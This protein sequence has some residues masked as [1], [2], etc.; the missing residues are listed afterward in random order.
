MKSRASWVIV[1]L[2]ALALP[3][4]LAS[5]GSQ[6]VASTQPS[7]PSEASGTV[8]LKS[9]EDPGEGRAAGPFEPLPAPTP[10]QIQALGLLQEEAVSYEESAKEYRRTI[11]TAVRHHYE[12]RRQKVLASLNGRIESEQIELERARDAAMERLEAFIAHYS[13]S[14]ADPH[15]T[16]DAMFR[17][18]ALHEEKTRAE[19][20]GD[21]GPGLAPAMALYLRIIQEF[22]QYEEIA[23][24]H[25]YLGHAYTDV[26]R[27]EEG[28][29]AWRSLVCANSYRVAAKGG[30]G[31]AIRVQSLPQDHDEAFWTRWYLDNP[32]PLDKAHRRRQVG[33]SGPQDA[34][35]TFRDPYA[36]CE[37]LP[38]KREPGAE[39]RYLAETWWQLGNYHFDGLDGSA[40]P[41][42]LSRAVSAYLHSLDYEEPPLHGV[43]L[44]KLAWSHF[45]QQRYAAAVQSFVRLLDYADVQQEATGDPG[46]DFRSEAYTYIA[47]SLTYL[48]LAGPPEGDPF[49]PRSDVLDVEADPVRA[50]A[51]MA[52][53][54]ERV[55]DPALIPQDELWTVEIYKA[56]AQEFAEINQLRN[57]IAALRLALERFPLDR[58]AP[59][60]QN[61]V[62]DLYQELARLSPEGSAAKDEYARLALR[63][64]T[65][66]SA[67]V[68]STPWTE[69]NREDPAAI[70][71]AE[72][73]AR[74][75]L[76]RAA[77][78]H[79][80]LARQ[81]QER[82]RQLSD[83]DQQ[84][85]LLGAAVDSYAM[86]EQAW[87]AYLAQDP[88]APDAYDTRF[89]LADARYK[90]VVLRVAL[91]QSPTDQEVELAR[92]A[93][94]AVRDSN[95]DDKYLQ[96]AAFYLVSLSEEVLKD[97]YRLYE[98]SGGRQGTER[99]DEVRFTGVGADRRVVKEELPPLVK[100]AVDARDEYNQ[101]IPLEMDPEQNGL[102]Y[103]YQAADYLFVYGQFEAARER[104]SA[105]YEKYCGT[106]E[107]G[108]RAW[109]KLISMSNF[110][111]D[112]VQSRALADAASCAYDEETRRAEEQIRKPVRQGVAYLDARALYDQAE[113]APAGPERDAKWRAAAA[114][115][116]Q[117]L[118]AAPD[119][120]EAPEAAM[121]GAFAYKQ[122]GE[123][124]K[125][126]AMY[127]LLI[128]R[129]GD[130]EAL[131]ALRDGTA[132]GEE[133]GAPDPAR[134]EERVGY[135]KGAFDALAA[136]YVLFFN[137]P[138]AAETFN[139]MAVSPHFQTEVRLDA[140]RQAL[141]LYASLGDSGG[142]G[143][144]RAQLTE[145]QASPEQIAEA[146]YIA[147]TAALKQW[148][149]LSPNQGANAGAREAA[150]RSMERF[151]QVH[152]QNPAAARYLVRAAY[153]V[154]VT[155]AAGGAR[156]TGAWRERAIA[157]FQDWKQRAPV[158]EG[159]N[160]ALGS[161]EAGMAAE[162]DYA[163][164]D[165]ALRRTFDYE[166]GHHRYEGTGVEVIQAFRQDAVKAR[167]WLDRLQRVVSDYLSP[168]WS[169]IAVARQGSLYDSLRSG[170]Y[171]VRPPQL[172]MFDDKAE[173]ML[174]KAEES[175]NL[176]L[177]EQ[178]DALRT[179]VRQAWR[180]Q[181]D[182][183]LDGADRIMVDRYATAIVYA[184]RY[185]VSN[186]VVSQAV[187]RLAFFTDV[188]GEARMSEFASRVAGLAYREGMFTR[189]RP[190]LVRAPKADGMP[191]PLP[192]AVP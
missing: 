159:R 42:A 58:E 176:E 152:R 165:D 16:P 120:D 171:N 175:D 38:Q 184:K 92:Q 4:R 97:R 116:R 181:R 20:E 134:Y 24:V 125:A 155:K 182:R 73:L 183:E 164:V 105:I 169:T 107:W 68:G 174:K 162:L 135:L 129:Y 179:R 96:P 130:D 39:P 100:S 15:A 23:A 11:H 52:V 122:V 10:A 108:Y 54:L 106:N 85:S 187:R 170:L 144:A 90:G 6:Q 29:Q 27:L 75:G 56:L 28:Q 153:H 71:L 57:A 103:A 140:A 70:H 95:E 40:G 55:K 84:R 158:E 142:M 64:R 89:W 60:L 67:Y 5:A 111:G 123:Y 132:E 154:A 22:P 168:E 34:E 113:A 157:A 143:R 47:A 21:L 178:A 8:E 136:A 63:A 127:E 186:P 3:S 173:R 33:P 166:T 7:V 30:D 112:A 139:S 37:A 167:E 72:E 31:H 25:Y 78:D 18:A 117:A 41:Y 17:L 180:E 12:R 74:S 98:R 36:D 32:V 148:D 137:Y 62:A 133:R 114:A 110:E 138:R 46:A 146:D 13:G 50:E 82:A 51:A 14:N 53:A 87:S 172:K 88:G 191:A 118:D 69:A 163:L 115:Y 9:V 61:R 192:V 156:D 76:R 141:S 126:I 189:M 83:P 91:E 185:H 59:T 93:V 150:Q 188:L 149:R 94:V 77:A 121:N 124:D 109:E 1:P 48:D 65:D 19:F 45:K 44:Y 128:A 66:L 119:R 35:L 26:G 79:T 161:P 86:A 81:Y 49:I 145:L 2:L 131:R 99:R 160:V 101:R 147:A 151:F 43:A 102:L 80:N 190:G 177:Q 104:F